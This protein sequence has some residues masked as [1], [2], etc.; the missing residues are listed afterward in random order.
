MLPRPSSGRPPSLRP[1]L[2]E[3]G[4]ELG[5]LGR[6]RAD[7]D[8]AGLE[9]LLL[10][11]RGSRRARDDR[12][13]VAHRLAWWGGEAGDVPD[14][15][16]AQLGLDE[17]GGL[18]LLVPADLADHDH[19]LGLWVVAE[20][21]QDVDEGRADDRIAADPGDGRVAEPELCQLVADLVRERA[22]TG[23]EPDR[24]FAEDLGGDDPDI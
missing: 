21:R 16:L 1:C 17:G 13:R 5:G 2:S 3:L 24:A 8:T 4:D 6:R 9:R 20:E 19:V 14:R 12:T 10:R 22:G 23:D 7:A 15:R 11:L 18:L